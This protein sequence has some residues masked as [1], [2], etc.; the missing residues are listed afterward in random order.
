MSIT[1][2]IFV[3]KKKSQNM[4]FWAIWYITGHVTYFHSRNVVYDNA[5]T[6]G[7]QQTH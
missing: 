7:V 3:S 4:G 2:A 1:G 6:A 5:Q